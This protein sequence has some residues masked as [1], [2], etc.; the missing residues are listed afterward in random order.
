MANYKNY[1]LFVGCLLIFTT[2][3]EIEPTPHTPKASSELEDLLI[4][5]TWYY[6]YIY[7][8]SR[9]YWYE[10]ATENLEPLGVGAGVSS[11]RDLINKR[12]IVY[13]KDGTYQL[14]WDPRGDYDLGTPGDENWQP[15]F[16]SY[17][18]D[19]ASMTL[20][21]NKGLPDE[22]VYSITLDEE[23]FIRTSKRVM[24]EDAF[25]Q[26][27]FLNPD[28]K[29]GDEVVFIEW[30]RPGKEFDND[31]GIFFA[32]SS[33]LNKSPTEMNST[34]GIEWVLENVEMVPGARFRF[35][36]RENP[37]LC[38]WGLRCEGVS[39]TAVLDQVCNGYIE[40]IYN[41]NEGFFRVIFNRQTGEL[42]FEQTDNSPIAMYLRGTFN[43]WGYPWSEETGRMTSIGNSRWILEDFSI[44]TNARFKIINHPSFM[45]CEWGV[46][47]D[48][49]RVG[50]ETNLIRYCFDSCPTTPTR[51]AT[52][53]PPFGVYDVILDSSTGDLEFIPQ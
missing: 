40:A 52:F 48:G 13:S 46:P 30:F 39:T 10:Q 32:S 15:R 42:R 49:D 45:G 26:T 43:N 41:G 19:E 47:R 50:L 17:E 36:N 33:Y 35:S 20:T 2:C 31:Q 24:S 1:I 28:Y 53:A 8:E 44:Q 21:H 7:V 11:F 14:I 51:D 37:T 12:G 5:S 34:D 9:K 27:G 22:T 23:G 6:S 38:N 25:R 18:L 4:S 29:R 3:D 16:G